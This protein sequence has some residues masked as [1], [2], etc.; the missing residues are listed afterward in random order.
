MAC[1]STARRPKRSPSCARRAAV[2]ATSAEEHRA[3]KSELRR[4]R[5]RERL[6]SCQVSRT[7]GC[8]QPAIS[9]EGLTIAMTCALPASFKQL[10]ER[11]G[12]LVKLGLYRFTR[13]RSEGMCH[14]H[15]QWSFSANLTA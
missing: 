1:C 10:V 6:L 8:T 11:H 14:K 2:N 7:H 13:E 15:A 5:S 4:P 12:Q 3:G 9:E